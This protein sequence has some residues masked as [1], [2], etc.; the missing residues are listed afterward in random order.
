LIFEQSVWQRVR[1]TSCVNEV[2]WPWVLL[3]VSIAVLA[4]PSAWPVDTV[5]VAPSAWPVDAVLA[6]PSAL[7]VDTVSVAPSAWSVDTVLVAPSAW[8][9]DTVS[10]DLLMVWIFEAA[11]I[12]KHN[13]ICRS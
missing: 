6:A 12:N 4:V 5:S 11:W 2:V 7:P 13:I 1:W 8:S 9:V 10:V 3:P